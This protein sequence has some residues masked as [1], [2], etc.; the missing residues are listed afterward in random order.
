MLSS[1]LFE[2]KKC[3]EDLFRQGCNNSHSGNMSV[4]D[5]T[6]IYITRSG[7]QLGRLSWNDIVETSLHYEDAGARQASVELIVHRAIYKATSARAI[8]HSHPPHAIAKSFGTDEICPIDAEGQYHLGKVP[9]L[10]V[11]NAISS[12]EVAEKIPQ[13][14]IK[15]PIVVVKGHGSFVIGA[16]L[17]RCLL[18]T[19]SLESACKIEM[20]SA[21]SN[22]DNSSCLT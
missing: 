6:K 1:L 15:T 17:E 16:N 19:S 14:L 11:E 7:A 20:L 18:L 22:A 3:G 12:S 13:L 5:G 21:V 2:F 9:V 8:I 10:S 4:C